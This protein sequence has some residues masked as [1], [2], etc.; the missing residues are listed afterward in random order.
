MVKKVDQEHMYNF[1]DTVIMI[2]E[3]KK[4]YGEDFAFCKR[5]TDIGGKCHIYS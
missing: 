3:T 2:Q 5:W 4:W 1:F